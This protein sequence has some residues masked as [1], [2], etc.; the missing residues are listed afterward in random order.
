MKTK[1]FYTAL[2]L[3][4]TL[5]GCQ[6]QKNAVQPTTVAPE[7]I[8]QRSEEV[9]TKCNL[10]N[11]L[12]F[13]YAKNNNYADALAP[14]EALYADCPEL[15]RNI[16][17][18]GILIVKWQIENEKDPV[19]K[20]LL[21][22]K[23]MGVYDN[24]IKYF[25]NDANI[26]T[27]RIYGLKAIDYITYSKKDPLQKKAY[28]WLEKS[29]DGLGFSTDAHFLQ[30]FIILSTEI[31]K[32]D[33]SHADKLISDYIKVDEV[34][35]KN[36]SS[37]DT[38]IAVL[39]TQVKNSTDALFIQSGVAN[40]DKLD[41]IYKKKVEEN[42]GK[43]DYLNTVINLYKK[44]KCN[45]SNVY[46]S[47]A[48]Y[49][50]KLAPTTESAIACAEMSYTKKDYAKAVEYYENAT[51]LEP[52]NLKKADIQLNIAKI[53]YSDM[54]SFSKAREY[55]RSAIEFNPN[56]GEAY[57]LIGNMY[58]QSN[59]YDDPVLSKTIYWVAVDKFEK[60]RQVDPSIASKA[61][62]LVATYSRYFPAD[63]DIFMHPDLEKGKP[64]T[65][66]GWIGETTIC[67]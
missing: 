3:I 43:I 33:P 7:P 14:W 29:I 6:A 4:M 25:G 1:F 37:E 36:I 11:S 5:I 57:I 30:Y 32:K 45:A 58:A 31:Y 40:C 39:Y 61:T 35:S 24:R 2:L 15:S 20:E 48:V 22:D 9:T 52:E 62:G 65:V 34:L 63:N 56:F 44:V 8:K 47:A 67:R 50:H 59:I 38:Q 17:K 55:A 13:E 60:A 54:K 66:G 46:F 19:K 23:L 28:E 18:Y 49:A 64:F 16:Y 42:K 10:N 27:P 53:Y 51:K 12:F 26:P 41:E 21:V